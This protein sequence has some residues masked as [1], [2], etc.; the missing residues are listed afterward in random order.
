LQAPEPFFRQALQRL[1]AASGHPN[2]DIRFS[3]EIK[4]A[5]QN[6]LRELGLDPADTTPQELYQA[7]QERV[8]ADDARL[9]RTLRTTAATHISAEGDVVAGMIHSLKQLPDSKRC[10]ALKASAL[11]AILKEVPPKKAMK[12][13]GYRSLE[14]FVKHEPLVS[15]MAAAQLAE[16]AHWH[17]RLLA[18]YKQFRASDFESR[19]IQ[20]VE[21]SADRWQ[22][23]VAQTLATKRHNLVSLKELGALAFL[24]L[25]DDAPDGSTIASMSL[26]LH[27]LNEIRA[28]STFLKLCQ[29]RPDFGEIF[30]D[31]ASSDEP[32]I[33]SHLL[34]RSVPWRLLQ[35]YYARLADRG[36]AEIVEPHLQME[37][38]A[39]HPIEESLSTVEPSLKFWQ[40]SGH[41]GLMHDYGPVSMNI[42]DTALGACNH[43]PFEQRI[44]SY[45]QR[46]LQHELMLRYL[47]PAIVEQAVIDQV[48][49]QLTE[50]ED[51][52]AMA[53]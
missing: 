14:S 35:H 38:I 50:V 4:R 5:S 44:N 33:E 37:D 1:E 27:E 13:L 2:T 40:H 19:G 30:H 43:L 51:Q 7:L 39:W 12:Q 46:T 25:P 32:K 52:E 15:V 23:L 41:L 53:A 42:V 36:G 49:P 24:P 10:F 18:Q 22:N 48:Q 47:Q 16:D 17:K 45:F 28:D 8:R 6:K 9:N 21:L 11:K 31:V 26:A 29:V 3:T 20:L 34:D